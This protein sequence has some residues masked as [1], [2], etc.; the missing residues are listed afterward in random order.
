M[1]VCACEYV[2]VWWWCWGIGRTAGGCQSKTNQS[3]LISW[4]CSCLSCSQAQIEWHTIANKLPPQR[5]LEDLM[6]RRGQDSSQVSLLFWPTVQL[7]LYR[8]LS[9]LITCAHPVAPLKPCFLCALFGRHA[10]QLIFFSYTWSSTCMSTS[11]RSQWHHQCFI[12]FNSES[13]PSGK[14]GTL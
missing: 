8:Q 14:S 4:H 9:L 2:S 1:C 10:C 5:S 6:E 12:K 3:C 13:I 11:Q 7:D